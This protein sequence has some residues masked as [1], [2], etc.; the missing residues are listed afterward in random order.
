MGFLD[1]LR[2][3]LLIA[4]G[5]SGAAG[6]ALAAAATHIGGPLLAPASAM[7]L[8]HAPA[9]IALYLA[10]GRIRTATSGGLLMAIGLLLFAGD[11]VLK[12][13]S[14][15]APLPMA[16]PTGGSLMILSWLVVGAGALFRG[17]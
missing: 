1:R 6:V 5:L 17:R 14:G 9:L 16:A 12:Q 3:L 4:A 10:E 2:P 7:C 15:L 8:A 13:F 11:L